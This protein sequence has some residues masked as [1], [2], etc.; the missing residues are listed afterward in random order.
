MKQEMSDLKKI[1]RESGLKATNPRLTVLQ[2]LSE[3]KYPITAQ[4]LHKKLRKES[5]D[6]V[7]LYRTLASFEEN[8]LLRKVDLQKEAVFYELNDE[9]HHHIVCTN[10]DKLEDFENKEVEKI[11]GEIIKKSEKFKKIKD[12]SLELFG[13]CKN[14]A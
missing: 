13:L 5:I 3:I 12:H 8:G 10:C 11:I 9:H 4:E 1:L 6:L 2:M 14:C 7:T